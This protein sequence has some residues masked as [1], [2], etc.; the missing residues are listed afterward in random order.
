MDKITTRT[1]RAWAVAN[2]V[3]S[4]GFVAGGVL[5][6]LIGGP[7]LIGW[8]GIGFF[9]ACAA[10][11]SWRL[12][13]ARPRLVIDD[14]GIWDRRWNAGV[15]EW[16]DIR[17][18]WVKHLNDEPFLCLEL[19]DPAKYTDRLSPL[20]K[21]LVGLNRDLGFSEVSISLSGLTVDPDLVQQL[22]V[23]EVAVRGLPA[24]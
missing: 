9:G 13:D 3:G 5:T 24:A 11:F 15:I 19:K 2:L 18:A 8:L 6:L 23:K 14:K 21:R 1:S 4:L 7:P 12:V 22:V 20:Q 16:S 10:V 17:T